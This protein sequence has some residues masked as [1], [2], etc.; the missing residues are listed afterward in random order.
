[1]IQNKKQNLIFING[2][3]VQAFFDFEPSS[4][5][6]LDDSSLAIITHDFPVDL[7]RY[8]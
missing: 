8:F 2:A 4:I 7:N 6:R 1:M 3:T 5:A